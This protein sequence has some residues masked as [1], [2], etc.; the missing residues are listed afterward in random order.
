MRATTFSEKIPVTAI[1]FTY[2]EER[3]LQDCLSSLAFC[4][5]LLVIDLGSA[6]GSVQIA[7][8]YVAEVFQ[9]AWVPF[10]EQALNYALSLARNKWILRLDPDEVFPAELVRDLIP[11]IVQSQSAAMVGLP[12]RYYFIGKPLRTT[13]WGGKRIIP[14]L[15][16][17]DRVEIFPY[18]HRHFVANPGI[19]GLMLSPGVIM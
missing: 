19:F 2:N 12:H 6:D 14:R 15:F 16:H 5:Q 8:E 9:H 10:A 13:I 7:G 17:K 11:I 1:V 18:V 4:E 3:R